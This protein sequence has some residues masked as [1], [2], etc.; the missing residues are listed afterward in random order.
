MLPTA[1]KLKVIFYNSLISNLLQI[2]AYVYMFTNQIL[3]YKM[4]Y[5]KKF[6]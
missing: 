4:N 1:L 2:Y 5:N 3:G 6:S